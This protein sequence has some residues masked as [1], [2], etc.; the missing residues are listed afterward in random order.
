MSDIRAIEEKAQKEL[1][2]QRKNGQVWF[3]SILFLDEQVSNFWMPVIL[4][5]KNASELIVIGAFSCL[6]IVTFNNRH[7]FFLFRSAECTVSL[8]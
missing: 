7:K 3:Y 5:T 6:C 4:L 8:Q 1:E 2:D